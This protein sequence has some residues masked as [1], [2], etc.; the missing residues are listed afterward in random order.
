[1][2]D[3]AMTETARLAHYV[4][5]AASQFEKW[6]ATGFNLEF[7]ENYFH[8]RHPLFKPQGESLPEPEIYTRIL[9]RM[10]VIPERFPMLSRIALAQP[11][12]AHYLPYL[13]ALAV[14]LLT[15]R[16]WAP[17][18][19]SILYRTLGPTLPDGAAAASFVLPLA[20]QYAVKHGPAVKRA[21]HA[22]NR[23]TLGT[24]L[25]R[26]ILS[27]RSGVVMSRHEFREV[28]PL[29]K[30]SDRRI[31]LA[32]PEMFQALG[33]LQAESPPDSRYPFILMAGERRSYNANQIYRD[34]AWRKTDKAGA[35][36]MHPEDAAAL[37]VT[38]GETVI[39]QSDRDELEVVVEVDEDVRRGVLTLPHG[40]GM[41]YQ[42]SGPLG[43]AINRLT[44]SSHCD[45][46]TKTPYHKYVPVN[47][48]KC[49]GCAV[50]A[51]A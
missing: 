28:W 48:R 44:S 20:I 3:V 39:C 12:N 10:G 37:G 45:P 29:L 40:Y 35:L 15:H 49:A 34:P 17:Y 11:G 26:A 32:I 36:R 31:H 24:R 30:T 19:A 47:V 25:F 51:T 21:G 7:P 23:L 16:R 42:N 38:D 6:E 8:L 22:G 18:A 27:V 43:P 41:R 1:V 50:A 46:F 5:P 33:A 9:E 14:T 13:G 4:L 2:I